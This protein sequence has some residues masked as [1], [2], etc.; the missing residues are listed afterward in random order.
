MPVCGAAR[1]AK[2]VACASELGVRCAARGHRCD[3]HAAAPV[4]VRVVP[5]VR[6]HNMRTRTHQ[7]CAWR[8]HAQSLC[9]VAVRTQ[10][11]ARRRSPQVCGA[12]RPRSWWAAQT[13]TSG[14]ALGNAIVRATVVLISSS[15]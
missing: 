13:G 7:P 4:L 3:S 2:G 8:L 5:V 12:Q 14:G 10:P 6:P 1:V 15:L 9:A 11:R